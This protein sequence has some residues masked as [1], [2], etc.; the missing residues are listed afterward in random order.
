MVGSMKFIFT[1][2]RLPVA[3]KIAT[4][5]L[6]P[7]S[8]D[9]RRPTLTFPGQPNAPEIQQPSGGLAGMIPLIVIAVAAVIGG[10][11]YWAYSLR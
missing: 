6:R 7:T 2:E 11:A 5:M 8:V 9:D 4:P 10:A 3:M 1:K